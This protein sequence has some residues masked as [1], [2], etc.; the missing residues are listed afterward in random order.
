MSPSDGPVRFTLDEISAIVEDLM[1]IADELIRSGDEV[2]AFLLDLVVN[3]LLD[4]AFGDDG[5]ADAHAVM[6]N[7]CIRA[8]RSTCV[9]MPVIL[10]AS[11]CL[12]HGQVE[13]QEGA[14]FVHLITSFEHAW[15]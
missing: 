4:R 14:R 6:R 11:R 5:C 15:S 7:V 9:D 12:P 2:Y 8:D 1:R 10:D 13:R 3:R